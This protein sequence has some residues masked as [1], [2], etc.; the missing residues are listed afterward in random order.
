M[1]RCSGSFLSR[2]HRRTFDGVRDKRIALKCVRPD[3]VVDVFLQQLRERPEAL[4]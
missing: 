2:Q 3:G 4:R 1:P